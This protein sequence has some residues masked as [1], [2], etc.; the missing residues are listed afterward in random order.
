[1]TTEDEVL[2]LPE[3]VSLLFA[4]AAVEVEHDHRLRSARMHLVDPG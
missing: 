3:W 1:M 2:R 4:G